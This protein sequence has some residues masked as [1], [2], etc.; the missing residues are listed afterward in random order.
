MPRSHNKKRNVGIIY[1]QIINFVCGRLLEEDKKSAENAVSIIKS[2][3]RPSSQLYKEYKL[4]KALATT[5]N[6][7]DQLASSII[8]EAKKAC[9]KMFNN[10]SLEKEKSSLIRDLNYA[11]GKGV[12]FEEKVSNYRTYATIQTLLNEWR[13]NSNNFDKTTE[14]EIKLHSSLTKKEVLK[15]RKMP[16]SVD[17]LTYNIMKDK[18]NKKY[19]TQL[20]ESQKDIVC[21]FIN[22]EEQVIVEKYTKLKE[23][24]M[25][26][27]NN[28]INRC[29]N[30]ILVEKNN[31]I[32]SKLVSLDENDLSKENLQKFLIVSKLK[33]E[34]LGE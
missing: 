4:F 34:I 12:I 5:H 9:N 31:K 7:N 18:F 24:C 29:N 19:M 20:N 22:D 1:E 26:V 27:L 6:V 30:S 10:E 25:K 33:E 14:Y 13:N 3:F 16:I 8:N 2:H 11:F 21:S 32:R 23:S 17:P 28:Y 15:E